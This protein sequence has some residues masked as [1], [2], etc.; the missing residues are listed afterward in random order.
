MIK[1]NKYHPLCIVVMLGLWLFMPQQ[2]HAQL[3]PLMQLDEPYDSSITRKIAVKANGLLSSG[4]IK[5][6]V[7]GADTNTVVRGRIDIPY[8]KGIDW[9]I[10]L[11]SLGWITGRM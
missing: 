2:S 3:A 9:V 11:K 5:P 6:H 1:H 10:I 7:G 8:F 4:V